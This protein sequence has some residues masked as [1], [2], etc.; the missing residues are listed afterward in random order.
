[1]SDTWQLTHQNHPR[2]L[3]FSLKF[4]GFSFSRS[5]FFSLCPFLLSFCPSQTSSHSPENQRRQDRYF[6]EKKRGK[7]RWENQ[8]R[9]KYLSAK[10]QGSSIVQGGCADY[11]PLCKAIFILLVKP[12]SISILVL[13]FFNFVLSFFFL[14]FL[15]IVWPHNL[16]YISCWF[17]LLK[18]QHV[19]TKGLNLF[20]VKYLSWFLFLHALLFSSSVVYWDW[21]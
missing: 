4:L 13:N 12:S 18:T 3:W 8:R 11:C 15:V 20:N 9:I 2:Q 5:F 7:S 21:K 14:L 1:M 17:G 6:L 16:L 10:S 19:I